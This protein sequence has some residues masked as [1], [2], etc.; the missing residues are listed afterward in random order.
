MERMFTSRNTAFHSASVLQHFFKS[1]DSELILKLRI[2]LPLVGL[3]Y[4]ATTHTQTLNTKVCVAKLQPTPVTTLFAVLTNAEN[5]LHDSIS[6]PSPRVDGIC[7][8]QGVMLNLRS[9]VLIDVD[10]NGCY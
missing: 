10:G 9:S 5:L 6:Y 3:L 2:R 8:H 1:R 7:I 4:S